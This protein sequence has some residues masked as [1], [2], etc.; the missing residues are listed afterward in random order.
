M[1]SLHQ[2][3]NKSGTLIKNMIYRLIILSFWFTAILSSCKPERKEIKDIAQLPWDSI[4]AD[5]NGTTVNMMMWQGD[6][7][8]NQY[9]SEFVVP[10]LKA[11]YNINLRLSN[12]QGNQL[13]SMVMHEN[14]AGAENS[15]DLCWINGETFFQLRQVDG[16]YGPFTQQLPN[17]AF[18]NF[19]NPFINTDFQQPVNGMECP[20]GNVQLCIIYD[21]SKV[22]HPPLTLQE[23]ENWVMTNPGKFTIGTDFT[24]LTVLKSWLISM[25]G[26]NNALSGN[27][28][29]IKYKKYSAML[30][31]YINR[32]KRYWWKQ[33]TTFPN[34]VAPMHQLFANGELWFTMSN[35]DG[36]VD[37][38][39]QQGLFPKTARSF[40]FDGGTIQN[41]H[42]LGITKYASNVAGA[43]VVCNF[44]ISPGA[45]LEKMKSSVW[46]D[47]TVLDLTKLPEDWQQKFAALPPRKYGPQRIAIQPKALQELAPEYMIRLNDDFRKFVIEK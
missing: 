41:S 18:I 35:N 44:L 29:E 12:G 11:N 7:N 47:G 25:S 28:D 13:V 19:N 21:S 8:I 33:G 14:Q 37:N 32:S 39:V 17:A 10:Q 9:M 2:Q 20:W 16:L 40:V 34:A 3:Y 22:P 46:G 43:M 42:Y 36:E 6:P 30:W 31:D 5:A 1:I 45:Q 27:F 4:V 24:G 15:M 38:K 23:L 26:G